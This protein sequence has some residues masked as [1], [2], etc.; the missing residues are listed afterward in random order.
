LDIRV[1]PNQEGAVLAGYFDPVNQFKDV[2]TSRKLGRHSNEA[3]MVYLN[4]NLLRVN[5]ERAAQTLAHEFTHL[6]QWARDPNEASWV[7]EGTAVYA[8]AFLG[9]DVKSRIAAYE[10][11][12]ATPLR[13]WLGSLAN[14]GTSYLF[15]AYLSE[16]YGGMEAIA[17][18]LRNPSPDV[19]GIQQALSLLGRPANFGD[20]F[21][22]WIIANYLDN[23]TLGD[24]RYG[25]TSLDVRPVL[26][27]IETKYPV[28]AKQDGV[29]PW[30]SRYLKFTDGDGK[31]LTATLETNQKG[32][33]VRT[34]KVGKA[35]EV[36][37]LPL[38][39][40]QKGQF[41]IPQFG[42]LTKEVI[43]VVS[44][45]PSNFVRRQGVYTYSAMLQSQAASLAVSPASKRFTTWGQIK[46]EY[47]KK[48]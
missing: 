31:A 1:N 27:R 34:I 43:L 3:E 33:V 16:R 24:G 13:I 14:Y 28:N 37:D 22:D 21:S 17:A 42:T 39:A 12:P 32:I 45:Q 25:Y 6:V 26:S 35:V 4:S 46:K 20:I 7:D 23:P 8:E 40:F 18:I 36:S 11:S 41:S 44:F 47:F 38:D 9:Y 29:N 10:E 5:S 30:A 48:E 19:E 15:F 2:E